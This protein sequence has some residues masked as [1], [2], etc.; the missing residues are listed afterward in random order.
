M[1]FGQARITGDVVGCFAG[2]LEL[3]ARR[4]IY[5]YDLQQSSQLLKLLETMESEAALGPAADPRGEKIEALEKELVRLVSSTSRIG[6]TSTDGRGRFVIKTARP[7]SEILL[8][9]YAPP[10]EEDGPY[11]DY[12]RVQTRGPVEVSVVIGSVDRTCQSVT[13]KK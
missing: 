9:A 3:P 4:A 11:A 7:V 2:R 13:L 5:A 10:V 8:V 1:S 6:Q 12:V